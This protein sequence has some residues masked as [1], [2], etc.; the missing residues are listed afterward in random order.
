MNQ[1]LA[2]PLRF[3]LQEPDQHP[4]ALASKHSNYTRQL[5]SPR[6]VLFTPDEVLME[7]DCGK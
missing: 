3:L 2:P 1:P 6:E 4:P 5:A 7:A